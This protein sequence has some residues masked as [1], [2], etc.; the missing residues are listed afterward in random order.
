V[1]ID[2]CVHGVDICED[3]QR[4]DHETAVHEMGKGNTYNSMSVRA[5]LEGSCKHGVMHTNKECKPCLESMLAVEAIF[6]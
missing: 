1:V 5:F 4:C 6:N 2:K 3:C